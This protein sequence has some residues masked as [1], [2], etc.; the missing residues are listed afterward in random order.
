M[1]DKLCM[2]GLMIVASML[3]W[4]GMVVVIKGIIT[5]TVE[6]S[7]AIIGV[8]FVWNLIKVVNDEVAKRW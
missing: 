8:A 6:V 4:F 2:V 1:I 5:G 7:T 3:M